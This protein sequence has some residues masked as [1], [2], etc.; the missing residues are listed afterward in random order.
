MKKISLSILV[1]CIVVCYSVGYSQ[2]YI[3]KISDTHVSIDELNIVLGEWTGSLIYKNYSDGS[4]FTMPVNLTVSE[5]DKA[6]E[7]TLYYACPYE[8]HANS[9][10]IL[11]LSKKG[12]KLN[13]HKLIAKNTLPDG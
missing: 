8:P 12:H 7:L 13:G 5:G 9:S 1:A 10:G 11:K 6:N 4:L 2:Q 3:S